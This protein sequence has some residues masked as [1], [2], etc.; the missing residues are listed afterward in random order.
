MFIVPLVSAQVSFYSGGVY[1][2][3]LN[4]SIDV[5]ENA[6]VSLDYALANKDNKENAVN[7]SFLNL[8]NAEILMG[9]KTIDEVGGGLLFFAEEIKLIHAEYDIDLGGTPYLK[10]LRFNPQIQFNGKCSS[11]RVDN[12]FVKVLLPI[13]VQTLIASNKDYKE[14]TIAGGRAAYYW[15]EE[16][17]YPTSLNARWSKFNI[18][19]S[20]DKTAI[21][22]V[23]DNANQIITIR[24][25]LK[26]NGEEELE[27]IYAEDSFEPYRFKAVAPKKEFY[28]SRTSNDERLIWSKNI[29]SL[30]PGESKVIQYSIKPAFY[31]GDIVLGP[32][33]AKVEGS[34]IAVS[35]EAKIK[36]NLCGNGICDYLVS[37]EDEST[38]HTDCLSSLDDGYCNHEKNLKC[39]PDCKQKD[40]SDCKNNNIGAAPYIIIAIIALSILIGLVWKKKSILP[41]N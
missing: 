33:I 18:D 9:N 36:L 15:V 39:D 16:K 10:E 1:I 31:S 6:H 37:N 41:K 17:R 12:Y 3:S 11:E 35:N 40:D 29:S 7:L 8:G 22:S 30:K 38:C 28:L 2:R 19:L 4:A 26:N 5:E 27:G 25:T 13:G 21:P 23:I 34:L 32:V 20:V 14:K 24:V